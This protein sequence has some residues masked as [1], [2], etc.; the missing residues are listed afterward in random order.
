MTGK[1]SPFTIE[2][3]HPFPQSTTSL[4]Q[5]N[6]PSNNSAITQTLSSSQL[7]RDPRLSSWTPISTSLK[8]I[9]NSTI[10]ITTAPSHS[11]PNPQHSPKSVTISPPFTTM[12][13]SPT[14]KKFSSLVQTTPAHANSISSLK[15]TSPQKPGPF[16]LKFLLVLACG[17]G[18]E[19][20][21]F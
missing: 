9:D 20:K 14:N 16:P 18:Y 11:P 21:T 15:F 17:V 10:S 4:H 8:P 7:T 2:G 19:C 3:P 13:T 6:R 12:A 5:K 1:P